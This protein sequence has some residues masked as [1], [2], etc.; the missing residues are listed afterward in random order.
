[1]KKARGIGMKQGNVG[2]NSNHFIGGGRG[3]HYILP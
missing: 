2:V 1:M 3:F